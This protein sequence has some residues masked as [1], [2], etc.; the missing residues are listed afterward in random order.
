MARDVQLRIDNDSDSDDYGYIHTRLD[1]LTI[2]ISTFLL[3][4]SGS[5]FSPRGGLNCVHRWVK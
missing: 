5:N 1:E 4:A 2:P 3:I